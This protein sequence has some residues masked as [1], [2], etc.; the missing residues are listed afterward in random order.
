MDRDATSQQRCRSSLSDQHTEPGHNRACRFFW[1]VQSM[2]G[3][4]AWQSC[5]TVC[6]VPPLARPTYK[7]YTL[8]FEPSLLDVPSEQFQ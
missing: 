8:G 6:L 7:V 2:P 1:A 5:V 4:A 3:N